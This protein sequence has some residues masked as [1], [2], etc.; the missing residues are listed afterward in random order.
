MPAPAPPEIANRG[1][2]WASVRWRR[3]DV[4]PGLEGLATLINT[5]GGDNGGAA[6]GSRDELDD[7]DSPHGREP[8][9]QH[10]PSAQKPLQQEPSPDSSTA[11][12]EKR[13]RAIRAALQVREYEIQIRQ[14]ADQTV[15]TEFKWHSR[16]QKNKPGKGSPLC[17]LRFENLKGGTQYEARVRARTL[18]GW[19]P[20]SGPSLPARTLPGV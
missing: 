18:K 3:P 20:F 10:E 1:S 5:A 14:I 2:T 12:P 13:R 8:P 7:G 6:R 17:C 19:S 4:A 9:L 11:M 16:F 15:L